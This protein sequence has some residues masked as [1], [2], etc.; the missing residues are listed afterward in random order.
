MS[1]KNAFDDTIEDQFIDAIMTVSDYDSLD[2]GVE[3]EGLDGETYTITGEAEPTKILNLFKLTVIAQK[4]MRETR[5]TVFVARPNS[6][7]E[8]PNE[9]SDL[10]DDRTDFLENERRERQAAKK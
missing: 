8:Q 6:W 7:Y 1:D 3:I 10:L 2:D 9:R 5:T 4:G